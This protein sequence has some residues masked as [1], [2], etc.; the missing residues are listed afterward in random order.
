MEA[1]TL[2]T[3]LI[4]LA[5]ISG[6]LIAFAFWPW[7][8]RANGRAFRRA[9]V[10]G[11][12][13]VVAGSPMAVKLSISVSEPSQTAIARD[14]AELEAFIERQGGQTL[15][16]IATT[17]APASH[18]DMS[19]EAVTAGL[20]KRLEKTPDDV[21]GWILLGRSY[22]ALKNWDRANTILQQTTKKWPDNVDVKVAYGESL[23]AAAD[24]RVTD[25]ARQAFDAAI[26]ID[27]T[28]VRARYN[29]AL[30]EFQTGHAD[31]AHADWLNLAN[32]LPSDS[33]WRP[34][35]QA[36]LD[37]TSAKLGITAPK[38]AATTP[39]EPAPAERGPTQADVEAAQ[40]LTPTQRAA[41]IDGMVESLRARLESNPN[42]RDGWLRLGKSYG[43][44]GRWSDA[45]EAY[46]KGLRKFPGDADLA[47]GLAAA[48]SKS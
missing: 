8:R 20:E 45:R 18:P 39:E 1:E 13:V 30:F 25:A 21:D 34:E 24:G 32:G 35:I 2:W 19:L 4:A 3:A 36:R 16:P 33:P 26:A 29:L 48:K 5:V 14:E 10:I 41:F 31:T 38:V 17:Q 43:V 44:L 46:E 27:P 22:A 12:A 40:S 11:A 23:M 47:A 37:E 15:A 6:G 28:N 7:T 42:D 9:L